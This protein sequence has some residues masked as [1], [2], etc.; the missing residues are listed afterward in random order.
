MA[1]HRVIAEVEVQPVRF[2]YLIAG[3]DRTVYGG[4]DGTPHPALC[5]AWPVAS[6]LR[7]ALWLVSASHTSVIQIASSLATS[8]ATT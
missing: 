8:V 4:A 7:A 2:L 1:C 6:A 5:Y 3:V